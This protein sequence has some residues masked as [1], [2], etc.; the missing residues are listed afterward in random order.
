MKGFVG[1][2]LFVF[3]MNVFAGGALCGYLFYL[4]INSWDIIL[5]SGDPLWSTTSKGIFFLLF[6]HISFIF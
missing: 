6:S 5:P 1:I 3:L 4:Q 2:Y